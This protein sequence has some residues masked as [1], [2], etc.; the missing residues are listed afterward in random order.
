MSVGLSDFGSCYEL[1]QLKNM[2]MSLRLRP[3]LPIGCG[4]H[5]TTRSTLPA[6]C[7]TQYSLPVSACI[8][9]EP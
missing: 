9:C 5:Y 2:P 8:R 1:R 7:G 3:T 6:S 4:W